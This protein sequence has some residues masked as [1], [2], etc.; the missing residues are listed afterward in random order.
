MKYGNN[1]DWH[2]WLK[3]HLMCG[4]KTHIVTSVEMSGATANDSPFYKP[5]VDQTA[6]AG[7]KMQE[8]S[9][10]FGSGSGRLT[11]WTCRP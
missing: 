3:M 2:D 11:K 7:F 1:E 9:A 8:V 10:A 6:K 5:L 4:V